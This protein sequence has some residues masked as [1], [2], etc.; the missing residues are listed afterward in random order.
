LVQLDSD[1]QEADKSWRA[2]EV[3]MPDHPMESNFGVADSPGVG[4][5]LPRSQG[6]NAHFVEILDALLSLS[7]LQLTPQAAFR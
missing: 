6:F 4:P 1:D 7:A 3:N 5:N 2:T